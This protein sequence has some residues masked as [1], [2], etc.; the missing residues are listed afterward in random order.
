[1]KIQ[2]VETKNEKPAELQ[3]LE[4]EYGKVAIGF[5]LSRLPTNQG[6]PGEQYNSYG[7]HSDGKIFIS[8]RHTKRISRYGAEDT[9]GCYL[10][11][12]NDVYSYTKNGLIL[13]QSST[14]QDDIGLPPSGTFYPTIGLNTEIY[15]LKTNFG[16]NR[17]E[18]PLTGTR[19]LNT[20][21]I[22]IN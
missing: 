10:D 13:Y 9:V 7:Y 22:V 11:L 2:T 18:F 20:I 4:T 3:K 19:V 15:A 8:G 17:F 16:E 6:L 21:R 5:S 14:N 12:E 1:M